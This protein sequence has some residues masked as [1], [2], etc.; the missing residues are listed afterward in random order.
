MW[1]VAA[2][3]YR[4]RAGWLDGFPEPDVDARNH[5]NYYRSY[6]QGD[7]AMRELVATGNLWGDIVGYSR[8]V[9]VGELIMV[10]GTTASSADGQA[11]HPGEAGPQTRVIL[12]RIAAALAKL[13][14]SLED[15][16]ETRVYVCDIDQWEAVGREHGAVFGAIKPATT[17][18]E[19]SRL[20]APGLVVEISATAVIDAPSLAGT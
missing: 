14:A 15:V 5:I 2:G 9:R 12:E 16:V 18:V 4:G 19:V 7:P 11:L 13:G 1:A 3:P 6:Y 17:M 10:S 8:A 20:I